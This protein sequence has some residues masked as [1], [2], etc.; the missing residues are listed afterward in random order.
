VEERNFREGV[1]EPPPGITVSGHPFIRH[2]ICGLL[3]SKEA[4]QSTR[5]NLPPD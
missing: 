4:H 3:F 1:V 5:I 2:D